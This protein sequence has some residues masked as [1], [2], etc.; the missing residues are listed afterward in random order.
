MLA[1]SHC[2]QDIAYAKYTSSR[3]TTDRSSPGAYPHSQ[4]SVAMTPLLDNVVRMASAQTW[5]PYLQLVRAS[6][7]SGEPDLF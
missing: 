3:M 1:C 7:S 4:I 6:L 2:V 5:R